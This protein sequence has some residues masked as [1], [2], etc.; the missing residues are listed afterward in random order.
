LAFIDC[1]TPGSHLKQNYSMI[2][3]GV[4]TSVDQVVNLREPHGFN[5]GA[6]AMPHGIVNNLH[7]HFT[8]EVFMCFD[9]DYALRWGPE[10]ADGTL[11]AHAGDVV[12]VPTWIFRGFTNV[13]PDDGFL[14]TCLGGDNTGGIIWHPSILAGAAAHGLYLTRENVLVDTTTGAAK[15]DDALLMP[16]IAEADIAAMR[17]WSVAE[18]SRRTV[19]SEARVFSGRALLDSVLPGHA[20]EMAP[21]IGFGMSAVAGVVPPIGN[22]HGFSME[23]LRVGVGQ[24]VSLHR[25]DAKQVLMVWRGVAEVALNGDGDVTVGLASRDMLSVPGGVWRAVRN[26]G[27]EAL[28]VLV[29]SAGDGRKFVEFPVATVAAALAAG[30]GIDPDGF[31]APGHLLPVYHFA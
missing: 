14:F 4:T 3:P 18:M 20:S 11:V 19:T 30:W 29:I 6:A 12:S 7:M 22:A 10:G 31:V 23:W 8:A 5:I 26:V 24:S 15:P 1:K 9:G 16:P 17:A 21:V 13:G 28:E 27:D 25:V 2:G